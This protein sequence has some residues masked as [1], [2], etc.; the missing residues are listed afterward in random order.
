MTKGAIYSNFRGKG[1][2]LWA[3]AAGKF[4][5]FRPVITPGDSLP[6]QARA[7]ARAMMA[8]TPQAGAEAAFY[9]ELQVYIRTDPELLAIQAERQT[10]QFDLIATRIQA[11]VGDRLTLPARTVSLGIQAVTR[12]FLAQWHVTPDEV[13]EAVVAGVYEALLAGAIDPQQREGAN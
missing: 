13:T 6:E 11:E 2:L 10:A 5:P 4:L 12:G 7:L 3:A 8:M 1:E 9:R